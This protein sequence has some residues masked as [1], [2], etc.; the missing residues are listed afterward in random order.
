MTC[1]LRPDESDPGWRL[2]L[3]HGEDNGSLADE[4]VVLSEE[5]TVRGHE[6]KPG[7]TVLETTGSIWLMREDA[8]WLRNMLD[9]L[10]KKYPRPFPCGKDP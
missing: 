5:R 4:F 7:A 2:R 10:L 3:E 6:H 9:G 1:H 8:E